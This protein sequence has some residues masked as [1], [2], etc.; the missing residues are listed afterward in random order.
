MLNKILF[1]LVKPFLQTIILELLDQAY[2]SVEQLVALN[3]VV[4]K[5][6][7]ATISSGFSWMEQLTVSAKM[8]LWLGVA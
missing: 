1:K 5:T 4:T 8:L 7:G 6:L 2:N 3:L